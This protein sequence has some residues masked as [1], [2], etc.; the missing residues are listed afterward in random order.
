MT[1]ASPRV[2]VFHPTLW[3]AQFAAVCRDVCA[4]VEVNSLTKTVVLPKVFE[5]HRDM[6]PKDPTEFLAAIAVDC[7]LDVQSTLAS[8]CLFKIKYHREDWRV[9]FRGEIDL[10]ESGASAARES[11]LGRNVDAQY[12]QVPQTSQNH[13]ASSHLRGSNDHLF[14]HQQQQYAIEYRGDLKF[15]LP[16]TP[17][18]APPPVPNLVQSNATG[19]GLPVLGLP[20][21]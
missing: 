18:F 2:L 5:A 13:M 10:S 15:R 19:I 7:S 6:F 1:V 20:L 3:E 12:I 16:P 11:R 9:A 21:K 14:N 8:K 17:N 4:R